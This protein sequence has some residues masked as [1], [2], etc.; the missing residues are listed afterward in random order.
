MTYSYGEVYNP[1]ALLE[2]SISYIID[3]NI[4]HEGNIFFFFE[5]IQT[6]G[7]LRHTH[8]LIWPHA[9]V[10]GVEATKGALDAQSPTKDDGNAVCSTWTSEGCGC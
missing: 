9:Y 3:E 2:A 4:W 8:L 5:K 6:P 7:N 1:V 10:G